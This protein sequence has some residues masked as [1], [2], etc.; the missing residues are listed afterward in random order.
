MSGRA[1]T[2]GRWT[3]MAG[4]VRSVPVTERDENILPLVNV[5]F[6]L[7]LWLLFAGHL[8]QAIEGGVNPPRA[9]VSTVPLAAHRLVLAR[10]GTLTLNGQGISHANLADRLSETVGGQVTLAVVADA[11]GDTVALVELL[12][13]VRATG[14]REVEL[15][16]RG[17]VRRRP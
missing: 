9:E 2:A 13:L 10:D 11:A 14:L 5:I 4:A 3:G 7:L 15:V 16:T 12:D 1:F 17:T 6:L 8:E